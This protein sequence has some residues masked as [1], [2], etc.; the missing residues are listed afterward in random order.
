[1]QRGDTIIVMSYAAY[2]PDELDNYSPRVVHVGTRNE[3]LN[4]DSEVATLLRAST[5]A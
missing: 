4:T 1:M 2:D 3:I 5:I